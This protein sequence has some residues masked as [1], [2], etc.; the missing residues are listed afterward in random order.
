LNREY[1]IRHQ[2][3]KLGCTVELIDGEWKSVPFKAL[4]SPLWRK[5]SSNFESNYTE[6]GSAFN[7]Y[8]L[9]VGSS[10]HCITDLS[11]DALLILGDDKFE[12]K[13]KDGVKID[14]EVLYYNGI[15]R[16]LKGEAD[17]N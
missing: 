13:H 12:F 6:L 17:E 15:L 16:K 7:E 8:Y 14:D 4:I 2:I 1:I 9:Y 11:D 10:N 3:E 5:K